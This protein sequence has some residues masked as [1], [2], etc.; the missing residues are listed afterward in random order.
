[1]A[2]SWEIP[3]FISDGFACLLVC[4]LVLLR[5]HAV[6]RVFCYFLIFDLISSGIAFVELGAFNANVAYRITWIGM[7]VVAWILSLWMVYA[8]LD[9][10][11]ANF[12]GIFKL[13]RK[14]L[15]ATLLVALVVALFTAEPEYSVGGLAGSSHMMGRALG[16]ALV[17]ERVVCSAALLALVAILGFILWFPVKLPRNLVVF[18]IGFVAYFA[19]NTG[20]L[21][22]ESFVSHTISQNIGNALTLLLSLCYAYMAFSITAEGET[23]YVSVGHGWSVG[24]QKRLLQQLEDMN[25]ALI[26][27]AARR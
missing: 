10:V 17:L 25:K 8:L 11:L 1:M 4:R 6:Y 22:I 15:N 2:H 9:A 3:Q 16:L 27:A 7:R 12:R 14:M 5:L 26:R 20:L 21:L 23:R 18:S 13:S 24:E 19:I